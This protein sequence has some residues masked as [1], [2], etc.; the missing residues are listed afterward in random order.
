MSGDLSKLSDD[1]LRAMQYES[2]Q[3][4]SSL[5]ESL[6]ARS[7]MQNAIRRLISPGGNKGIRN[8]IRQLFLTRIA[9][10]TVIYGIFASAATVA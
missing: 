7:D 4:L 8:R 10:S 6:S 5:S 3:M 1:R 2:R 9:L